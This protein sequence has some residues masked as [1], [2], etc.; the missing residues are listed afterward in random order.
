VYA[1]GIGLGWKQL[2]GGV[3]GVH[4][5]RWIWYLRWWGPGIERSGG[6]AHFDHPEPDTERMR[7]VLAWDRNGWRR[8]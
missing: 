8:V 7:L 2:A 1:L 4:G 3:K 5:V 6:G